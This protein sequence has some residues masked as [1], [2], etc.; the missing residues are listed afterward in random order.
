MSQIEVRLAADGWTAHFDAAPA[1]LTNRRDVFL[2]AALY[3][4]SAL[5]GGYLAFLVGSVAGATLEHLGLPEGTAVLAVALSVLFV[6]SG[7]GVSALAE[8]VRGSLVYTLRAEPAG[9]L[10]QI[11]RTGLGALVPMSLAGA[12]ALNMPDPWPQAIDGDPS[13]FRVPW[14]AIRDLSCQP[15]ALLFTISAERVFS[16]AIRGHLYEEL[17][18]LEKLVAACVQ[19]GD[20]REIPDELRALL[21]AAP[22]VS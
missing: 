22:A 6:W 21:G 17:V 16:L 15:H 14:T 19:Q 12:G 20:P 1:T 9:L 13:R 5:I 8:A 10:V 4:G 18:P 3:L 7:I 2:G 11:E